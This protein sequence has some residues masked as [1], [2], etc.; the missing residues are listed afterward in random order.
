MQDLSGE[1][2]PGVPKFTYSVSTD[3]AQPIGEWDGRSLELYGHADYSHRSSFNTSSSNSRYAQ[4]PAYGLVNARI[5]IR[6]ADGKWDLSVW[7][8]NL[9]DKN[10]FQTLSPSAQGSI[11]ALVGDPRTWGA[12][13]RTKL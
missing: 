9:T 7:V 3:L 8:K 2:L 10:Y 13:L 6:D 12:T 11:T 5:G 1:Q 4:L